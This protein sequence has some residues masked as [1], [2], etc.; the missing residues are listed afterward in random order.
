MGRTLTEDTSAILPRLRQ[1]SLQ[2]G[3]RLTEEQID[4]FAR[5]QAELLAW[6]N[7]VN[8]TSIT[9]PAEVEVKHF[10][11]SLTVLKGIPRPHG[12]PRP[13]RIVDIGAGAGFPGIPLALLSPHN[14]VTLVET[15]G[16]KCRFLEHIIKTLALA[17]VEVRCGRAED[18][19]RDPMLREQFD[20]VVA[21]AVAALPTL[22]EIAIPYARIGGRAIAM[23]KTGID[24][25]LAD[26]GYA[27]KALGGRF[28]PPVVV[29]VPILN[30]ERLLVI[31]EKVR[32][33]SADFPRKAGIPTK[34]PLIGPHRPADIVGST[35]SDEQRRTT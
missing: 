7:R 15:T 30:E 34:S 28:V 10:L 29:R 26:A 20:L 13:I 27:I 35:P 8:L 3:I 24:V 9:D 18:L 21:R 25:E 12:R 11:D 2:L 23:K 5:Y 1:G 22:V 4:K 33:T 32:A 19:A 31:I 16:K 14:R 6:N 17:N